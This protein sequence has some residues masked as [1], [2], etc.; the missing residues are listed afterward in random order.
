MSGKGGENGDNK[1]FFDGIFD[2]PF[3]GMFDFNGDGKEDFGEQWLGFKIME[4]LSSDEEKDSGKLFYDED[5]FDSFN[6]EPDYLWRL[7]CEEGIEYGIDPEDYKTEE[8]YEE[9]LEDAKTEAEGHF[10][11]SEME[12]NTLLITNNDAFMETENHDSQI[13]ESVI[14]AKNET[15][16]F[17]ITGESASKN[18]ESQNS[19]TVVTKADLRAARYKAIA[20]ILQGFIVVLI[21]SVI[22]CFIIW[23]AVSGYD[24]NNSASWLVT[25]IFAGGGIIVLILLITALIGGGF[26]TLKQENAVK[27]KYLSSLSGYEKQKYNRKIRI[28][29]IIA[30]VCAVLAVASGVTVFALNLHHIDSIYSEAERL[31]AEEKFDEAEKTLKVI[32]KTGY[33]DTAAL[34]LLCEAHREYS[35]GIAGEAYF[36]MRDAHFEHQSPE[37]LSSIRMFEQLLKE[38]YD[39]NIKE[40]VEFELQAHEDRIRRGVPYVGMGE[41]RIGDTSLGKPSDKVEHSTGIKDGK[42]YTSNI[43]YFYDGEYLIF[44][45]KCVDRFVTEVWDYRDDPIKPRVPNKNHLSNTGPS[46]DGF[47]NPEDFYDWYRDD[48]FDYYDA[49]DYYY[50]HGGKE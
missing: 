5:S 1:G 50:K 27:R 3:G 14:E 13:P 12:V 31:I 4:Q 23:A 21:A 30:S 28:V 34:L 25:L 9:A 33:K 24:E 8:E 36:I 20:D 10:I 41:S 17:D 45:A 39:R 11:D 49:E 2:N 44:T 48:F 6:D 32:E 29:K 40:L 38:E 47:L 15:A 43:Y 37:A 42:R 18:E 22:P 7:T 16:T 46:V 35:A 26:N 19:V